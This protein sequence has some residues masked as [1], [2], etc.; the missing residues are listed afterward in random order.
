[1]F[2]LAVAVSPDHELVRVAGLRLEVPNE[3]FRSPWIFNHGWRVKELKWV[4]RVPR[5]ELR[6]K[7]E[8]CEMAC[9]I[10]D[11]ECG[12]CSWIVEPVVFYCRYMRIGLPIPAQKMSFCG[13]ERR[14]RGYWPCCTGL[15]KKYV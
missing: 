2:A 13:S 11:D 4:A 7:V 12:A 1:V 15:Q 3:I 6:R 8:L 10:G 5:L 9:D 14:V